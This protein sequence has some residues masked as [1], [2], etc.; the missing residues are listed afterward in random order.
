[1]TATAVVEIG[2]GAKDRGGKGGDGGEAAAGA[3]RQAAAVW[4]AYLPRSPDGS[5]CSGPS[6][7]L[8][9]PRTRPAGGAL[10]SMLSTPLGVPSGGMKV[11]GRELMPC[12]TARLPRMLLYCRC[13]TRRRRSN[14]T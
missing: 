1:M 9:A 10:A 6:V 2:K 4:R 5:P 13:A 7:L 12:W 8:M 14:H 3:R 11:G